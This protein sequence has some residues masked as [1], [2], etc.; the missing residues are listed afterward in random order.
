MLENRELLSKE[1]H[2]KRDMVFESASI[3][4]NCIIPTLS[5]EQ[6]NCDVTISLI[7]NNSFGIKLIK[8]MGYMSI[9]R[10]ALFTKV[11]YKENFRNKKIY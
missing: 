9:F 4:I 10:I 7:T 11:E 8:E 5:R 2:Q 6:T 1:L 3:F